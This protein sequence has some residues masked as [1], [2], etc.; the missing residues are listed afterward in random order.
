MKKN[1]RSDSFITVNTGLVNLEK[2]KD[3]FTNLYFFHFF[4]YLDINTKG[5][6]FQLPG[7]GLKTS[8]E[9]RLEE[10]KDSLDLRILIHSIVGGG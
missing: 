9:L 1:Y 4:D 2:K 8:E 7:Y 10:I 6:I 5:S 3:F